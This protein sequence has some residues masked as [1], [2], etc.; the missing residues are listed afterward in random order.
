MAITAVVK[1][2]IN[3]AGTVK[4]WPILIRH[5]LENETLLPRIKIAPQRAIASAIRPEQQPT[6]KRPNN[7]RAAIDRQRCD[8]LEIV[9]WPPRACSAAW[10][11]SL[12]RGCWAPWLSVFTFSETKANSSFA[13][14]T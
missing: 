3:S 8:C 6:A 11:G 1:S 10:A 4:P 14:T 5:S 13:V 7:I 9:H 12:Y 2:S